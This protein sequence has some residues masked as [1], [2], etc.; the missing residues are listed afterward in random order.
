MLTGVGGDTSGRIIVRF[1][2]ST[3]C[4]A[5]RRVLAVL[6]CGFTMVDL[7][8]CVVVLAHTLGEVIDG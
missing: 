6:Q 8:S 1:D 2:V 7:R 4:V 3:T 5:A